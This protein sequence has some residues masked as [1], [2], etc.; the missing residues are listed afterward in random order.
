MAAMVGDTYFANAPATAAATAAPSVATSSGPA[1][2]LEGSQSSPGIRSS[3]GVA[4][5]GGKPSAASLIKKRKSVAA[6]STGGGRPRGRSTVGASLNAGTGL[7]TGSDGADLDEWDAAAVAAAG[8]KGG[9]G[10]RA[11]PSRSRGSSGEPRG[12]GSN[13]SAAGHSRGGDGAGKA[14]GSGFEDAVGVDSASA[15]SNEDGAMR[16]AGRSGSGGRGRLDLQDDD[17][18]TMA[19]QDA[20]GGP[21]EEEEE[22][23]VSGA[24]MRD[25][26]P[27][28]AHLVMVC[29]RVH[30]RSWL[31]STRWTRVTR[32]AMAW[33]AMVTATVKWGRREM[34]TRKVKAV[35]LQARCPISMRRAAA[36]AAAAAS[37]PLVRRTVCLM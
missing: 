3:D 13:H 18:Y 37:V 28:T 32:V 23:E 1:G 7:R 30:V 14:P 4:A 21:D 36:A 12:D 16:R 24:A 15:T 19:G 8:G 25:P 34:T 9:V 33:V 29:V 35:T 27:P 5:G 17:G 26:I 31:T 20:F 2:K 11:G 6:R 22:D 10:P